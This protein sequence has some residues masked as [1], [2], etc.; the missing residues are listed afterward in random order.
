MESKLK[1]Y[2]NCVKC[3]TGFSQARFF[4]LC[5][6]CDNRTEEETRQ[7]GELIANK[8]LLA[9]KHFEVAKDIFI[10]ICQDR[11]RFEAKLAIG[12]ANIFMTE[13]LKGQK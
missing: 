2:N 13:Y 10:K 12:Y 7:L 11:G 9:D 8:T 5:Y 4:P 3:E 1:T 6:L